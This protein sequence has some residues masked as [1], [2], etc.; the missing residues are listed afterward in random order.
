MVSSVVRD[1]NGKTRCRSQ[2][3][4]EEET[5]EETKRK[6]EKAVKDRDSSD[7]QKLN[8]A[9]KDEDRNVREIESNLQ[10]GTEESFDEQKMNSG[11]AKGEELKRKQ[12]KV[13]EVF[14]EVDEEI[15]AENKEMDAKNREGYA[16]DEEMY[17]KESEEMYARNEEVYAR[18]KESCFCWPP[19]GPSQPKSRQMPKETKGFPGSKNQLNSLRKASGGSE[20]GASLWSD[21][22]SVWGSD[23]PGTIRSNPGHPDCEEVNLVAIHSYQGGEPGTITV[24]SGEQLRVVGKEESGWVRVKRLNSEEEGYVPASY[25]SLPTTTR[26]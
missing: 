3:V 10:E 25:T 6:W 2:E 16:K 23:F 21:N 13:E 20:S 19:S 8:G 1:W 24:T 18:A 4:E 15:Y 11:K 22:W 17:A 26:L 12:K 5:K 9:N 14:A 7:V